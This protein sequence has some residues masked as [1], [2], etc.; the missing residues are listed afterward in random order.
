MPTPLSYAALALW[1]L[2][3]V[4]PVG[5]FVDGTRMIGAQVAWQ[6][7]VSIVALFPWG[8]ISQPLLVVGLLSNGLFVL[9]SQRRLAKDRRPVGVC[10][11]WLCVAAA[12]WNVAIGQALQPFY[13]D[14]YAHAGFYMWAAA[15]VALAAGALLYQRAYF[16]GLLQRSVALAVVAAVVSMV[17]VAAI[18]ML[19]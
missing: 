4:M 11:A 3:W 18:V 13:P 9:E 5:T 15:F 2:S 8:L 16:A 6:G 1:L 7:L 17:G 12:V 10:H 19:G 14:L